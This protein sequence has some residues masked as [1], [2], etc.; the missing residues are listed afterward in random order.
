MW[1]CL[2]VKLEKQ[3]AFLQSGDKAVWLTL[4]TGIWLQSDWI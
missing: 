3:G 2:S 4:L 1:M